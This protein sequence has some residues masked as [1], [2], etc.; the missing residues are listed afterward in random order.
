MTENLEVQYDITKKSKF[1]K[2]YESNKVLIYSFTSIIVILFII[3]NL[4][5]DNKEK[6][7]ISQTKDK[8][9][10]EKTSP[11]LNADK[12]KTPIFIVQGAND[13]R[14]K[15]SESDQM[16]K[17]LQDRGVKVQ[18]MVK[19]NEGHGF[20]NEENQFDFYREMETFLHTHISQ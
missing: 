8:E 5:L 15:K 6:K 1:K 13:P 20:L 19:D 16:V 12:I 17:A 11:A 9:Q 3:F 18:Y 4:Y 2:F 7:K 14:V 10:F